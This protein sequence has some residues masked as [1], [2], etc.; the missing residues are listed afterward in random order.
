MADGHFWIPH[1][2]PTGFLSDSIEFVAEE[3]DLISV[4]YL[5]EFQVT[6]DVPARALLLG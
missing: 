4:E 6:L 3:S 2:F 1:G 5:F